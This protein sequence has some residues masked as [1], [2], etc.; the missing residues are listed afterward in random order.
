M[1]YRPFVIGAVGL[2]A[3]WGALPAHAWILSHETEQTATADQDSLEMVLEGHVLVTGGGKNAATNPF[4]DPNRQHF[5]AAGAWPFIQATGVRFLGIQ[6]P[7]IA[8][9]PGVKR[10]FGIFGDG[11]GLPRIQ[12]VRWMAGGSPTPVPAASVAFRPLG[13]GNV[14]VTLSNEGTSDIAVSGV[15]YRVV[16]IN[17]VKVENLNRVHMPPAT[18][19]SAGIADGTVLS[20]YGGAVSFTVATGTA[21]DPEGFDRDIIVYAASEFTTPGGPPG[22][23][24]FAWNSGTYVPARQAYWGRVGIPAVNALARSFGVEVAHHDLAAK[25]PF[26]VIT[27][28]IGPPARFMTALRSDYW[29]GGCVPNQAKPGGGCN[30]AVH[31]YIYDLFL[32]TTDAGGMKLSYLRTAAGSWYRD[33]RVKARIM[34]GASTTTTTVALSDDFGGPVAIRIQPTGGSYYA[35]VVTGRKDRIE[36]MKDSVDGLT[37]TPLA[38]ATQWANGDPIA[39]DHNV[40][41][42]VPD[43]DVYPG[44]YVPVLYD[45]VLEAV[46][47][48]LTLT[49]SEVG[50]AA[51]TVTLTATDGTYDRGYVGLRTQRNGELDYASDPDGSGSVKFETFVLGYSIENPNVT[52]H[53]RVAV[54]GSYES[55]VDTP[56]A[57]QGAMPDQ[58]AAEAVNDHEIAQILIEEGLGVDELNL[59]TEVDYYTYPGAFAD[60]PNPD[61]VFLFQSPFNSVFDL[62]WIPGGAASSASKHAVTRL[63]TALVMGEHAATGTRRCDSAAIQPPGDPCP[64]PAKADAHAG[65]YTNNSGDY[66]NEGGSAWGPGQ[67]AAAAQNLRIVSA[68]EGGDPNHPVVAGLSDGTGTQIQQVY[69]EMYRHMQTGGNPAAPGALTLA[70]E[71]SRDWPT[72]GQVN[73]HPAWGLI[74]TEAGNP[75]IV[76]PA[77]NNSLNPTFPKRTGFFFCGDFMAHR[78]TPIGRELARRMALWALGLPIPTSKFLYYGDFD[79]DGDVDVNDFAHFQSCF[80]GPGGI[81]SFESNCADAD[82]DGDGDVDVNDFATFQ[83]CFNG[84]SQAPSTNCP[85][86]WI[87]IP[88]AP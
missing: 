8:N 42:P 9:S 53:H 77:N 69:A 2:A 19:T 79:E 54:L 17:A 60:I 63:T 28:V 11:P 3:L 75:R 30:V 57:E 78:L 14:E 35:S 68:A 67:L 44:P 20:A 61:P 21:G 22:A 31:D 74:V 50:N 76:D 58:R 62:V 80:N 5:T 10:Q 46:G 43:P 52:P 27:A 73:G 70:V 16:K 48:N 40:P 36:L 18:F 12:E 85:T 59:V 87:S 66:R 82:A 55:Q 24:W 45:V 13:G 23:T 41:D 4:P 1:R 7:L 83:V 29:P 47:S 49:V 51:H 71:R 15:G 65:L 6:K 25:T 26:D 32:S 86:P 39:L 33:V 38:T 64:D 81:I 34:P 88:G 56:D 84:P 72:D 37:Q